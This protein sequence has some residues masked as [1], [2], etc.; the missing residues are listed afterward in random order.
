MPNYGGQAVIEGVMMRGKKAAAI[1]M[2]APDGE[3]I[4][5]HEEL[6]KIYQSRIMQIPFLRGLIGLYD[7]L[8]LGMKALTIS[9]NIQ[10]GEEEKIEGPALF[11]TFALSMSIAVVIFFLIPAGLGQAVERFWEWNAWLGNLLEGFV[12][13]AF[14][15]LYMWGIGQMKDIK[16]VF[17][18]HGAEHKVIN[19]FEAGVELVPEKVKSFS[20]EHPRCGTAFLLIVVLFSVLLFTALGPMTLFWRLVSR[21]LLLPALAGVAYEYLRWTAENQHHPVIKWLIKPNLALQ[22][23]TTNEPS[24]DIIEVS[25]AAFNAMREAE[26]AN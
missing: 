22:R 23:L 17:S 21:V 24:L 8:I 3:I 7:A 25:I 26:E 5:H 16:R 12:R 1:A 13:L 18:Y 6:N 9:A 14:L 19:T 20:L 4:I 2:R 15:I 10:T 11:F